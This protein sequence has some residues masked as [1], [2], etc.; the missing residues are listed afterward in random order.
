MNG[1]TQGAGTPGT[2]GCDAGCA[3]A[4]A[5]MRLTIEY[6]GSGFAG[7][8]RQPAVRTVQGEIEAALAQMHGERIPIHGAGRTDAGVHALGQVASFRTPKGFAPEELRRGVNALTGPD[9]RITAAERVADDFHARHSARARHYIYLLLRERSAHWDRRAYR[10]PRF[11]DLEA[12]NAACGHLPG[13]HDF[14]AFSVHGEDQESTR[15]H[16]FYAR[17]EPWDRGVL[18]R[19]GAVRFL[20]KMVRCLVAHSVAVGIGEDDP[21]RFQIR[22]APGQ[23]PSRRVAPPQGVHLVRIDYAE[24]EARRWGPDCLPP[25]PVL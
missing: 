4:G 15:S 19:V 24:E 8:Q 10:P 13:E 20:Y 21:G 9:V 11:P 14:A 18:F 12:M 17:W 22:L 7:W 3:R 5:T 1:E 16:L 6:D 2:G 23:P 25:A